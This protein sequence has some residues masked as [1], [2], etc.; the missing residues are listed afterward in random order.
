MIIYY[1]ESASATLYNMGAE[2]DFLHF[3]LYPSLKGI[4]RR[5]I[6]EVESH[7]Q[8]FRMFQ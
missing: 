7:D 2:A 4:K 8:N 1:K 5:N 3:M 6:A